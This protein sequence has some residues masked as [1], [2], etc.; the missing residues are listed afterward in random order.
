MSLSLLPNV[1]NKYN[2]DV[3][4]E[5][6][7]YTGG[8]V[9]I[10][11]QCGFKDIYSIEIEEELQN[12]NRVAFKDY[13]NVHLVTGDSEVVMEDMLKSIDSRIT[14][15][16]DGH[17]VPLPSTMHTI[18]KHEIPLLQELDIIGRHT[19]N[20]HT[21]MIDDR[22]MMGYKEQPGDYGF[23]EWGNIL[24]SLVKNKLLE[25]NPNYSFAFE[26]TVN[27]KQDLI[28]AYVR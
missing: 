9:L 19:R 28:V 4:F 6:G 18:G 26:D 20:D 3:F 2:N 1:L 7:T 10:A 24:E 27:A 5:T 8:G 11:L 25:I 23:K 12:G 17:I 14:F 13:P 22:R 15:F 21:I 16:L